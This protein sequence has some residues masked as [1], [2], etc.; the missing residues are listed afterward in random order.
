MAV[1]FVG[2][3]EKVCAFPVVGVADAPT[4]GVTDHEYVAPAG[5]ASKLSCVP[6]H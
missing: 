4:G 1:V 5:Q 3:N 6:L 2:V